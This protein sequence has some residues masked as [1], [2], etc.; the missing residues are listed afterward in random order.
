MKHLHLI[1]INLHVILYETE[2]EF[3]DYHLLERFPVSF[4][5][6][7]YTYILVSL[8]DENLDGKLETLIITSNHWLL[9][10]IGLTVDTKDE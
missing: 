9:L 5:L 1:I 6:R 10:I 4:I 7:N 3:K 8:T 2:F